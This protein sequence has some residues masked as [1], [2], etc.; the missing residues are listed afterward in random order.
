MSRRAVDILNG[1][2]EHYRFIRGMVSWI[3]LKQIPFSYDRAARVAGETKYPLS[4]MVRFAVD[5]VTGFSIVPLRVASFLGITVGLIGLF[6][7]ACTLG[8]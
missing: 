1:M 3:G 7:L 2:P 6:V 4:K 8:S 5:A